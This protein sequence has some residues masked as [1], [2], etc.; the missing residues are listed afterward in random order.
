LKVRFATF[1]RPF[2]ALAKAKLGDTVGAEVVI[3]ATPA[4]CYACIRIRGNIGAIE[5]NWGQADYWFA[6]A[7]QQAP[8][9]PFAYADWGEM[10]LKKGDPDAAIAKFTLANKKGPKFADPLEGWG[11]ALMRKDRSDLAPAKFEEANKYIPNRGRLHLMWGEALGYAGRK[12]ER[13]STLPKLPISISPMRTRPNW[14]R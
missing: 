5:S 2:L 3:A 4:D 10:L 7:V 11:E 13:R 8:S 9:I 6:R 1:I 12:D 14:R